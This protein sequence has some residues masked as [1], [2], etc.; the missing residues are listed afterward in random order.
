MLQSKAAFSV[1]RTAGWDRWRDQ[2]LRSLRRS[3]FTLAAGTSIMSSAA[4]SAVATPRALKFN[5]RSVAGDIKS[6]KRTLRRRG[7]FHI[8]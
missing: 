2:G 1:L 3:V 5:P 7:G 8:R 6:R 4:V